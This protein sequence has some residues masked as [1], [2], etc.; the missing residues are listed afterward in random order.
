[1][2]KVSISGSKKRYELLFVL[3]LVAVNIVLIIIPN[4]YDKS[5]NYSYT[6][7]K[8][9]EVDNTELKQYGLIKQGSQYLTVEIKRGE[10]KGQVFETDNNLIGKM[11]LD[12]VLSEGDTVYVEYSTIGDGSIYVKVVDFYRLG[13]E[14][15]LFTVFG[16]MLILFAGFTGLKTLL[17][18]TTTLLVLWKV[19]IPLYLQGFNPV[20][21][22]FAIVSALTLAI[23]FLV[24]GFTRKGFVAFLGSISGV[25]VT[26]ILSLSFSDP[27]YINGS[28]MPFA[29]T[30]LYSGFAHLDL[31]QLFLA[32]IFIGSSGAVMDIG[33]DLSASMQEVVFKN[34][35]ITTRELMFSGFRVGRA[36]VGTMTT[37]LLFAYSGGYL[38][39][40]MAFMAQGVNTSAMLNLNYF[41]SEVLITVIGS[42]GLVLTAPL[43]A[44]IGAF[45]FTRK[46]SELL[47][48]ANQEAGQS[49]DKKARELGPA[50]NDS[51]D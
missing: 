46:G 9:V 2:R 47:I 41:S 25:L 7:G 49:V 22:A 11:E 34:P 17:S 43:T 33:M 1:M 30:L 42:F 5:S 39:L 14:M 31:N 45:V 4:R 40:L 35:D 28:V 29:E 24:G 8:I 37:T 36:V 18:F 15:L 6:V 3:I 10:L 27:F 32:S 13:T 12:K 21:I 48:P 26:L 51:V 19:M 38:T 16:V 20:L 23:I 50:I 44:I